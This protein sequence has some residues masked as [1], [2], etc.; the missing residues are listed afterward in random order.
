[1]NIFKIA[2]TIAWWWSSGF[3]PCVR[4]RRDLVHLTCW[5]CNGRPST[6][7][8]VVLE[9]SY[10]MYGPV[11]KG[12][13]PV[14]KAV[15][16]L[17]HRAI[18]TYHTKAVTHIRTA[19]ARWCFCVAVCVC[20]GAQHN[21]IILVCLRLLYTHTLDKHNRVSR[22]RVRGLCTW[23]S[24]VTLGLRLQ[25]F[26]EQQTAEHTAGERLRRCA[27]CEFILNI[28]IHVRLECCERKHIYS[29]L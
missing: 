10:A 6:S 26:E 2:I 17:C 12:R 7:C 4:T 8:V 29:V 11:S 15:K 5:K 3:G 23:V 27:D 1:M 16:L 19:V 9:L 28:P 18:G 25:F 13:F 22:V 24:R 20:C 21:S 14:V